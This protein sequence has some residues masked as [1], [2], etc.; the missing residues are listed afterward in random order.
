MA[1]GNGCDEQLGQ[2]E[3]GAEQALEELGNG[4]KEH[5]H[6]YLTGNLHPRGLGMWVM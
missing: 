1:V 2:G 3:K 4:V 6:M 5:A